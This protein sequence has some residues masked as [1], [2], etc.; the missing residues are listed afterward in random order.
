MPSEIL[1]STAKDISADQIAKDHADVLAWLADHAPVRID[2]R[3]NWVRNGIV[4][5]TKKLP[6]TPVPVGPWPGGRP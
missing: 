3:G 6:E 2:E 5:K 1:V 4:I